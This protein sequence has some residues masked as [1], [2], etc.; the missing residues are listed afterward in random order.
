[1]PPTFQD[2]CISL[3]SSCPDEWFLSPNILRPQISG[4][5]VWSCIQHPL[6]WTDAVSVQSVLS[7]KL[8]GVKETFDLSFL[9]GLKTLKN[10]VS[11]TRLIHMNQKLILP[12]GWEEGTGEFLFNVYSFC[13]E[14]W[15]VLKRIVVVAA[16]HCECTLMYLKTVKIYP[17]WCGSVDWV[18]D[19]EPKGHRF[20]SQ[21]GHMP[22]SQARSPVWGA[23][24]ATTHWC[25]SSSLSPSLPLSLKIIK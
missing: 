24:E 6:F 16:Q 11:K 8:G 15:K 21:S 7:R 20:D 17:G 23:W 19:W 2:F 22:G 13:W 12:G 5:A 10:L 4:E 9:P 18:P 1:M 3:R 25:V 14:W